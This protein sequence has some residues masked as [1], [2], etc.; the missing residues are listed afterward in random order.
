MSRGT[1]F[2]KWSPLLTCSNMS[3]SGSFWTSVVS[4]AQLHNQ[5]VN[6]YSHLLGATIFAA[7]PLQMYWESQDTST[8]V[9]WEDFLVISV[10][11]YS[12]AVCLALSSL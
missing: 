10:Y 7:Y 11:C 12:V 1:C 5:T 2:N 6:V 9:E 4:L 8:R 3:A